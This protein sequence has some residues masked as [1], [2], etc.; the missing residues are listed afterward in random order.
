MLVPFNGLC[1]ILLFLCGQTA[2]SLVSPCGICG[3]QSDI[4]TEISPSA[5]I[6]LVS[7]TISVLRT[8]LFIH[9]RRNTVAATDGVDK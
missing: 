9:Q 6:F 7:I 5:S 3:E 1:T 4:G 8:L 2:R